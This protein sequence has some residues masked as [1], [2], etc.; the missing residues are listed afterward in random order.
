MSE[1]GCR[2]FYGSAIGD[3]SSWKLRCRDYSKAAE[4]IPI[5]DERFGY[6][7]S[8][9]PGAVH[10]ESLILSTTFLL[11]YLKAPFLVGAIAPSSMF[12]AKALC[13]QAEGAQHLIELGAGTGAVT[14]HLHEKFP[15]TSLVVVERDMLMA[16]ALRRR[17]GTCTVVADAI[18]DREDLFK[19]IPD[20]SVAVSSLPFRSLPET[21]AAKISA[22]LKNFLLA[23]PKRRIV[24][25]TYG[26]RVPFASPH[27]ALTWKRQEL[28]LRNVPPAWVWTLQKSTNR[29]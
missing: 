21:V 4:K 13:R 1:S 27:P 25:Y 22:L 10:Y 5:I 29:P 15:E 11:S 17:F 3:D 16:A 14:Q 23:S 9:T 20:Q 8:D 18:Q 2:V 24:Q 26:Q 19:D 28:I 6:T 12:L 7:S